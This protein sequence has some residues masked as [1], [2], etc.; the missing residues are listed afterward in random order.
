MPSLTSVRR[1]GFYAAVVGSIG[2]YAVM[3]GDMLTFVVRG[4]F[5]EPGI[6]HFHDLVM[7]TLI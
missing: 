7:F 2:L 4:W 5:V 3:I 1:G 6:H